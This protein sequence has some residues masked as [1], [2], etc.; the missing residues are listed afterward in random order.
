VEVRYRKFQKGAVTQDP[1]SL[2]LQGYQKPDVEEE[3]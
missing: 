2:L 1:N 3:I